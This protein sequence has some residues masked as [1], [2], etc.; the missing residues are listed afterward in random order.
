MLSPAFSSAD[1]ATAR[2]VLLDAQLSG[3]S[4]ISEVLAILGQALPVQQHKNVAESASPT[5]KPCPTIRPD[6]TKCPGVLQR[7]CAVEGLVRVGCRVCLHSEVI[8]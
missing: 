1:R 8:K 4:T 6:G 2:A 7:A 3:L 5:P